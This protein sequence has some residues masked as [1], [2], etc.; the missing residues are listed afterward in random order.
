MSVIIDINGELV[1]DQSAG[2]RTG[3]D[4]DDVEVTNSAVS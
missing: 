2:L 4:G 3:T 1:L